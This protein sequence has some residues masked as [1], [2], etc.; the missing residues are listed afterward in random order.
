MNFSPLP[1]VP[2][3]NLGR[4]IK[5]SIVLVAF[6]VAIGLTLSGGGATRKATPPPVPRPLYNTGVVYSQ[7][8]TQNG[9]M[10]GPDSIASA[11]AERK[12]VRP[13]SRSGSSSLPSNIIR[14]GDITV[15]LKSKTALGAKQQLAQR[16]NQF[17]GSYVASDSA[18]DHNRYV[19]MQIEVPVS[20]FQAVLTILEDDFGKV[21]SES[22]TTQDVGVQV[23]DLNARLANLDAQ[24][25]ALL[26][27]FDKASTV[28]STIR[29]RVASEG[30]RCPD[31]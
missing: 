13:S 27:L 22:S 26:K 1:S 10:H 5:T 16:L 14:T 20:D 18:Y 12:S 15:R 2:L 31:S 30:S 3:L 4:V 23:V 28:A 25:L 19:D 6:A 24:R 7:A 17:T 29:V 8:A 21:E 11:G 9:P